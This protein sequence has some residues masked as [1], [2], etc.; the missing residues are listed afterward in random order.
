MNDLFQGFEFIWAWIYGLLLITKG[1]WTDHVH[2][3]E[4]TL[5]KLKEGGPKYNIEKSFFEEKNGIF[6]FLGNTWWH[7][8]HR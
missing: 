4:W 5:N 3:L 6:R 8:T 2:K 7:K 1:D